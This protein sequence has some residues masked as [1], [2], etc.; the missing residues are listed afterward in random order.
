[1]AIAPGR[2]CTAPRLTASNQLAEEKPNVAMHSR[3]L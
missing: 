2:A 3:T 1:M